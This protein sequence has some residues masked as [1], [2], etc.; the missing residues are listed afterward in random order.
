MFCY[1]DFRSY[2]KANY[3]KSL[4]FALNS[5]FAFEI[6]SKI[7]W[8]QA[9][10]WGK[11]EKKISVRKGAEW[12]SEEGKGGGA[13]YFPFVNGRCHFKRSMPPLVTKPLVMIDIMYSLDK[14]TIW[15]IIRF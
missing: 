12:K 13:A 11:K 4:P 1:L 10:H 14:V 9:R 5:T 15:K 3:P 8:D 6:H 7:A 2:L